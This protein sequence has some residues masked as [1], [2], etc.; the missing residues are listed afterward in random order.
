MYLLRQVRR[1][2]AAHSLANISA[3]Q[4]LYRRR[5]RLHALLQ[6]ASCAERRHRRVVRLFRYL[7][8]GWLQ[9]AFPD[10][11]LF[12]CLK[13]CRVTLRLLAGYLPLRPGNIRRLVANLPN[14]L[15]LMQPVLLTL[16]VEYLI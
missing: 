2:S 4:T 11:R 9:I 16:L 13:R 6:R 5:G 8:G 14:Q 10:Q 1:R 7:V 12:C 3:R 15:R